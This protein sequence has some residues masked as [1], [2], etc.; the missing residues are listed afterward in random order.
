MRDLLTKFWCAVNLK[1]I[2][3][4]MVLKMNCACTRALRQSGLFDSNACREMMSEAYGAAYSTRSGDEGFGQI[5]TDTV[6]V[7]RLV[8]QQGDDSGLPESNHNPAR[9]VHV[10]SLSK[11]GQE[12]LDNEFGQWL[13]PSTLACCLPVELYCVCCC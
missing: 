5:Y 12:D 13:E 3:A 8:H 7:H 4:N 11:A 9:A 10:V 6:K 2:V 1:K